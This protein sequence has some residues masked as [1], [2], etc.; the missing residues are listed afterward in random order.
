M[1]TDYSVVSAPTEGAAI[2]LRIE[3]GAIWIK[4]AKLDSCARFLFRVP[5]KASYVA[6]HPDNR[7]MCLALYKRGLSAKS[8][9]IAGPGKRR[10]NASAKR[11]RWDRLRRGGARCRSMAARWA[12]RA[13]QILRMRAASD[14]GRS[15]IR[16]CGPAGSV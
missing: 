1:N 6:V 2:L 5:A 4:V 12:L 9:Q 8:R 13:F 14:S 7:R 3:M 15:R 11:N 10:E 16:F